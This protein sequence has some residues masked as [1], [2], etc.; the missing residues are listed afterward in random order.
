MQLED[1][2]LVDGRDRD[3]TPLYIDDLSGSG[4]ASEHL[5]HVPADGG[6]TGV[7]DLDAELVL[8]VSQRRCPRDHEDVAVTADLDVV[9]AVFLF[10][11]LA[12][13]LL[14]DVL[15]GDKTHSGAELID[16]QR[17]V[18]TLAPQIAQ[19]LVDQCRFGD[20]R[21]W[22]GQLAE[23]RLHA[24]ESEAQ[25][26][27]EVDDPDRVVETVL[28][29]TEGQPRVQTAARPAHR[30]GD[31]LAEHQVV[32]V[33]ARHHDLTG[34]QVAEHEHDDARRA[35]NGQRLGSKLA[36][37]H[38]QQGHEAEG[39]SEADAGGDAFNGLGNLV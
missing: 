18:L 32:D 17:H 34:A 6:L 13:D 3:R 30:V 10:L 27:L 2:R 22:P 16:D 8:D 19:H 15:E 28:S 24:L 1:T 25:K 39:E 23:V 33:A 29:L 7:L 31:G 4:H 35:G 14:E 26:L 5:D 38:V 20:P 9:L 21:E 11:E 37:H 12:D 36:E